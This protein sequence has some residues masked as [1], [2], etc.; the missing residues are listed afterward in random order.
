M[1]IDADNVILHAQCLSN[2]YS[3]YIF[4]GL[5]TIAI[6]AMFHHR[7]KSDQVNTL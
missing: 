6:N 3:T 5:P 1:L 2:M 7:E 4:V